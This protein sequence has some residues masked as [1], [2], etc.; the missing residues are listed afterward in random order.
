M[1]NSR[2]WV[3]DAPQRVPLKQRAATA[4]GQIHSGLAAKPEIVHVGGFRVARDYQLTVRIINT[5]KVPCRLHIEP[6]ITDAWRLQTQERAHEV[7][8]PGLSENLALLFHPSEYK[9]YSD[10]LTVN[11]PGAPSLA[12]PLYGYPTVANIQVPRALH[13]GKVPA[14]HAVTKSI[15]LS[16]GIPLPFPWHIECISADAAF[17]IEPQSGTIPANGTARVQITYEPREHVTA[18]AELKLH[19]A[20]FDWQPKPITLSGSCVPGDT[21][22]AQVRAGIPDDV[23]STL[24]DT[25]IGTGK[26]RA[27]APSAAALAGIRDAA[28]TSTSQPG[29]VVSA[30]VAPGSKRGVIGSVHNAGATAEIAAAQTA[31]S[32]GLARDF[33]V[34]STTKR[35]GAGAGA[36]HDP[37]AAVLAASAVKAKRAHATA[38]ARK[39]ASRTQAAAIQPLSEHDGVAGGVPAP[40]GPQAA[41][42]APRF[43]SDLVAARPGKLRPRDIPRAVAAR[44]AMQ[45]AQAATVAAMRAAAGEADTVALVASSTGTEGSL[46]ARNAAAAVIGPHVS[47]PAALLDTKASSWLVQSLCAVGGAGFTSASLAAGRAAAAL[48]AKAETLEQALNM[49]QTAEGEDSPA[50]LELERQLITTQAEAQV[51]AD[52]AA[53]PSVDPNVQDGMLLESLVPLAAPVHTESGAAADELPLAPELSVLSRA[54]AAQ[55]ANPEAPLVGPA[56][57]VTLMDGVQ[58]QGVAPGREVSTVLEQCARADELAGQLCAAPG[59]QVLPEYHAILN[60]PHILARRGKLRA[61][62]EMAMKDEFAALV[63]AEQARTSTAQCDWHGCAAPTADE[64]AQLQSARVRLAAAESSALAFAER[65]RWNPV[66]AGDLAPGAWPARHTMA[67]QA[68]TGGY[69]DSVAEVHGERQAIADIS[70]LIA[71]AAHRIR[72]SRRLNALQQHLAK[73][74]PL[75]RSLEPGAEVGP[76]ALEQMRRVVAQDLAAA[77]AHRAAADSW[78]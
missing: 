74:E 73:H 52:T 64:I 3:S 38:M 41:A 63:M 1:S 22:E 70:A 21:A 47:L 24:R 29:Q 59:V 40:H 76:A 37:G 55:P 13:F 43:V 5:G 44:Q 62:R 2:P 18:T 51:A 20:Q 34:T 42:Q 75:R 9:L 56:A 54:M 78:L 31:A 25:M 46:R 69:D 67:K 77:R 33:N 23:V 11:Q 16:S 57:L 36:V 60:A 50:V 58:W 72:A 49:A 53:A 28:R 7:I 48:M 71:A 35:I 61:L 19:C 10:V 17:S 30:G 39:A 27:G 65:R 68:P 6:P 8:P 32:T 66:S 26:R 45:A 15:S 14:G 12:I 4:G